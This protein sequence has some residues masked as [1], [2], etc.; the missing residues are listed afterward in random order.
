MIMYGVVTRAKFNF[1]F[2]KVKKL[3]CRGLHSVCPRK[4]TI[5]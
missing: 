2:Q 3:M 4:R 5:T 1:D